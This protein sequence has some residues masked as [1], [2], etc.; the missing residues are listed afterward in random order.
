MRSRTCVVLLFIVFS[1]V[2]VS[3]AQQ[4]A[5]S[6]APKLIDDS[7]PLPLPV[8]ESTPAKLLPC[9][10]EGAGS[11]IEDRR[12]ADPDADTTL[13]HGN[14]HVVNYKLDGY[15]LAQVPGVPVCITRYDPHNVHGE[16][17]LDVSALRIVRTSIS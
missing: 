3:A 2:A 17:G 5:P 9:A 8:A 1:M 4:A 16:Y 14:C 12:P 15:C 11:G 6:V 10:A 7:D 13:L